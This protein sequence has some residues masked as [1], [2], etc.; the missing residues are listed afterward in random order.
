MSAVKDFDT[1]KL[2]HVAT[3]EKTVMPTADG[4]FFYGAWH[5]MVIKTVVVLYYCLNSCHD[6]NNYDALICITPS[7]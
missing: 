4:L 7:K 1:Q 5:F 3:E 2:K 6:V